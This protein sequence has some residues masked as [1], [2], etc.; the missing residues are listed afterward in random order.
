[1]AVH[2]HDGQNT[3]DWQLGGA[4]PV[5]CGEGPANPSGGV[6]VRYTCSYLLQAQSRVCRKPCFAYGGRL[7]GKNCFYSNSGEY[8]CV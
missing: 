5:E 8:R 2:R 3:G 4:R 1:M 6:V 7:H